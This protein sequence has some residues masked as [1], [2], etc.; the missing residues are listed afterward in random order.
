MTQGD[1]YIVTTACM[2]LDR[3]HVD[4]VGFTVMTLFAAGERYNINQ[5]Y[6]LDHARKL[7]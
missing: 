2:L 5:E 7:A 6:F 1:L 4:Q 3:Y